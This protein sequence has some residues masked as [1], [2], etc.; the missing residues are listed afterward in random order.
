MIE[1]ERPAG[2]LAF[3][4]EGLNPAQLEAVEA[5]EGAVLIFAGAGSG[6]TRVLTQR[7]VHLIANRGVWPSRILAVTF[8]NKAAREMRQRIEDLLPPLPPS[9]QSEA[10]QD[11]AEA[12]SHQSRGLWIGTFHGIALRILRRDAELA[13]LDPRFVIFDEDDQRRSI[14]NVLQELGY[15]TKR[16]SPSSVGSLISRMK[17]EMR[18]P[19]DLEPQ[20]SLEEVVQRVFPRYE[21]YLR[22]N[23][24]VDFDDLL[25][26]TVRLLERSEEARRHYGQRFRYIMV[27][28]YQDTNRPQ[29]EMIRL[30]AQEH[31][32]ICVVGDDDQSI[33]GWRGAD[34]RNILSFQR[35]WP[36]ARIITLE[37]NY[38]STQ[39]ILEGA[40]SVIRNNRERAPKKLVTDR[41]GGEPIQVAQTYNEVEEADY[42]AGEIGRLCRSHD[43]QPSD[44]AVLYRTNAQSRALEEAMLRRG[45]AYKLVGGVRFYERREV[46]DVLAYLRL[47]ANPR[48]ALSLQRVINVP[49]RKLGDR[50]WDALARA[51]EAGSTDILAV[52]AAPELVPCLPRTALGPL[53]QF[54]DLV[55]GLHQEA[56]TTDVVTLF[57]HVI[58]RTRLREHIDDGTL[59]GEERWANVTELRGL[60]EEYRSLPVETALLS[61]LADLP[62]QG[63]VDR[64]DPSLPG[65]TLIT[66]HMVKGL[67]FPVVFLCGMEEGL[68]PHSRALDDERQMEEERRLCYVGMT[69]AMH[70]LYLT[71]AFRRHLYGTA[72]HNLPSRFLRELMDGV[73][74]GLVSHPQ[75]FSTPI[76]R[77]GADR[78]LRV[79]EPRPPRPLDLVQ[80]YQA[81]D[82]VLHRNFG[83][84]QVMKSTMT[85]SDEELVVRFENAGLKIL[86]V[87][88]APLLPV[89]GAAG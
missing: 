44:F 33:Y 72:S 56:Q 68:F 30:L 10:P 64:Y 27:D 22:A 4:L 53:A 83:R 15:D 62:L 48:D 38:R 7:V 59:P 84:G 85:N 49:S 9:D 5:T 2:P 63:D 6:K 8:T 89:D 41:A 74:E 65:V 23:A 39:V 40:H 77:Q 50:T 47:A 58:E 86:K 28:E 51:A 69:R 25:L 3:A 78:H 67:E 76:P 19:A 11:P 13:G 31:G 1:T 18:G 36:E 61:F 87:S 45:I 88:L 42:V 75:E 26:F 24:A 73:P 20:N 55:Q 60:V 32:N 21:T 17:N 43:H 29:Y 80:R 16:Y 46:R 14:T 12:Q 81:G 54:R 71:C 37:Q 82:P 79:P 34:V 66:L 35:D 70:R 57:D 52:M